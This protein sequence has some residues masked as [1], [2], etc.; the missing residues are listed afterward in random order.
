MTKILAAARIAVASRDAETIET[1]R[2]A[3]AAKCSVTLL[4]MDSPRREKRVV[5]ARW[6]AIYL[7]RCFT[8]S[9]LPD[10]GRAFGNRDHTTILHAAR[11]MADY[12]EGHQTPGDLME[13]L[14]ITVA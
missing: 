7:A 14:G 9:S 4:E 6:L 13:T 10:I 1:I 3:V 5:F 2:R 11:K 12:Y 8:R